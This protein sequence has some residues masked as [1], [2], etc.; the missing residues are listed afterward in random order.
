MSGILNMQQNFTHYVLTSQGDSEEPGECRLESSRRSH[1]STRETAGHRLYQAW[2]LM[3]RVNMQRWLQMRATFASREKRT[4]D[5][6]AGIETISNRTEQ[7][8]TLDCPFR[9]CPPFLDTLGS[10]DGDRRRVSLPLTPRP[11]VCSVTR[12]RTMPMTQSLDR[13]SPCTAARPCPRHVRLS[14]TIGVS[15]VILSGIVPSVGRCAPSDGCACR[16]CL[17]LSDFR[18]DE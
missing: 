3:P 5:R 16:V 1:L 15:C 8:R 7:N 10:Q 4:R 9:S 12:A 2:R 17:H 13:H 14:S 11:C 6:V 18:V